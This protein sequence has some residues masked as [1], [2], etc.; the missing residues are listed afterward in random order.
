MDERNELNTTGSSYVSSFSK[1]E[2]GGGGGV[3]LSLSSSFSSLF[4]SFFSW[5]LF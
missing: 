3:Y 4:D 5:F 2:R 1:E